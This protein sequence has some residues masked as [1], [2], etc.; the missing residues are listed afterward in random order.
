M[1]LHEHNRQP[2]TE[3]MIEKAIPNK[4]RYIFASDF[5]QTLSFN[6]SGYVLADILG[7]P[8]SE[9]ERKATGMAKLNLVQQG[10]EL[11][12]LLLHDPEFRAKVRRDHLHELDFL[13]KTDRRIRM[14][15]GLSPSAAEGTDLEPLLSALRASGCRAVFR[16][17]TTPDLERYPVRAA[18]VLVT[19]LQP[20]HFGY[21]MERLGGR[22]LYELPV[23]LRLHESPSR[24][25]ELNPCPHPLA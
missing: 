16:D 7:I 23:K 18:R 22:R 14:D 25:D 19:Q 1:N 3:V 11:S 5:D 8:E 15:E 10:A 6:D 12:Y 9:F 4:K 17:L 20:I 21:G 24:E 13:L 2:E